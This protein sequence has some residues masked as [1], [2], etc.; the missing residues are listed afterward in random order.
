MNLRSKAFEPGQPIPRRH[1]GDG[2]DLSPELS[3]SDLPKGTA[4]LALIVD[5][6][7]APTTEPWVHWVLYK[8]PPQV[9]TLAE[10]VARASNLTNPAGAMQG[11][12]SW[13]ALG[14]RGPAPPKGHGTHH[15]HFTLYALDAPI[16]AG[17]GLEK[18]ELLRRMRGH[19]LGHAELI[20]TYQR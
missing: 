14:Y 13:G 17:P 12:N 5:D 3:W 11:R 20:G 19:L 6:P 18:A 10:G 9:D 1:T 7:D 2:Q 8:V 15:Y 16:D 4:E